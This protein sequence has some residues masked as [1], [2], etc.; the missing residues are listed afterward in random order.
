MANRDERN[1]YATAKW[2]AEEVRRQAASEQHRRSSG[3][4][5]R[6]QAKRNRTIAY[7]ACVL[8]VSCLLAGIGWLLV[9]DV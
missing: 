4:S 6:R 5:R 2:D 8:L 7:F 1:E 9:N 3:G